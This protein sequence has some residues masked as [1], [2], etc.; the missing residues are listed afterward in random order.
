MS[1]KFH[2]IVQVIITGYCTR[3]AR[4]SLGIGDKLDI[5]ALEEASHSDDLHPLMEN[6]VDDEIH[7]N[8]TT[9]S[10]IRMHY[11]EA[12]AEVLAVFVQLTIGLVLIWA[13]LWPTLA[14]PTPLN[15]PEAWQPRRA[16]T[17]LVE[18]LAL[19]SIQPLLPCSG[20]T[21]GFPKRKMPEHVCRGIL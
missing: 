10:V 17:S 2:S 4:I 3:G 18:F 6:L 9:W 14:I 19:T 13:S 7:N 21:R 1:P 16:S 8:H 5:P 20:S 11:R 15:G 12:L